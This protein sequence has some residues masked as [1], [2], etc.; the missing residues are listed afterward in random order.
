MLHTSFAQE[1]ATALLPLLWSHNKANVTQRN[2]N[3]SGGAV[4]KPKVRLRIADFTP[5]LDTSQPLRAE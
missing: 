5:S 3:Q 4:I 2:Y 1:R